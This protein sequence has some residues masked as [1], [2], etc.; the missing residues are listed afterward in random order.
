MT[1]PQSQ[2]DVNTGIIV[3]EIAKLINFQ[4]ALNEVDE[5]VADGSAEITL[6]NGYQLN[7]RAKPDA[8]P[9]VMRRVRRADS[10]HIRSLAD[11]LTPGTP[12][13][14]K[15]EPDGSTLLQ[16]N[17]DEV[18]LWG[19]RDSEVQDR[20][21]I[22]IDKEKVGYLPEVKLLGIGSSGIYEV[23]EDYAID[24]DYHSIKRT[25]TYEEKLHHESLAKN[26]SGNKAP[27]LT[28][29]TARKG[30]QFDRAS[31]PRVFWAIISKDD[32]SNVPPLFHD[33]LYRFAGEIP[34]GFAEP[35]TRFSRSEADNLFGYL[36]E[37]CGVVPWRSR[38]AVQAVRYF[39]SFAWIPSE[40]GITS[41]DHPWEENKDFPGEIVIQEFDGSF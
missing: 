12:S 1:Y 18:N 26:D 31:I 9:K 37:R 17:L 25:L 8:D 32:L 6:R 24:I 41:D 33:I 14:I 3:R 2:G 13:S 30:F 28:R 21:K 11:I 35:A 4:S 27:H 36:M 22:A 23:A 10:R 29:L 15:R 39:A 40:V 7:I 5:L 34:D 38:L 16:V 19:V 20:M